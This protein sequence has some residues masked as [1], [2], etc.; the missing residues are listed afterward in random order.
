[1]TAPSHNDSVLEYVE[2][3]QRRCPPFLEILLAD[4]DDKFFHVLD[5]MIEIALRKLE[6]ASTHYGT[7]DEVG[8]T[9]AFGM[10]F[11]NTALE[12][13]LES[14]SNGHV[15]F[16]IT[17]P[18]NA[19]QHKIL[20]EAK[21]H[22]GYA[23]HARGMGQLLNR[24]LTGRDRRAILL[25]YCKDDNVAGKMNTIRQELDTNKP[26]NQIGACRD[27]SLRWSFRSEHRHASG[28]AIEMCHIACNLY[29]AQADTGA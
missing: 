25:V 13:H 7:V 5:R 16:T 10:N 2:R 17:A 15:D 1:M 29:N 6:E 19:P 14:Y 11:S 21:I 3:M 27:H 4:S 8:L 22:H 24:Y 23:Y 26:N 20:G 12:C 28:E 9:M 18:H